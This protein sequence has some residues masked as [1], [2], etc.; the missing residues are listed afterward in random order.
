MV[1]KD[2]KELGIGKAVAG[3]GKVF[4]V[5]NY[6]PAGNVMSR[7][8]ENVFPL[9]SAKTKDKGRGRKGSTSSSSSSSSSSSD[10]EKKKSKVSSC[11]S[12]VSVVVSVTSQG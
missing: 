9:G 5:A 11:E 7:F 3:N 8:K 4:V 6:R 1:W 10:D 2:T 12:W